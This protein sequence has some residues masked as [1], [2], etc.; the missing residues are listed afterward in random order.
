MNESKL[1]KLL[2][3][4]ITEDSFV[5]NRKIFVLNQ[6]IENFDSI[7]CSGRLVEGYERVYCEKLGSP[8]KEKI[9]KLREVYKK[10]LDDKIRMDLR[11]LKSKGLNE[12]YDRDSL[13]PKE[14]IVRMLMKG[15]KE[16]RAHIKTLPDIPCENDNG[17]RTICTKIPE[18]VHVYLTGRY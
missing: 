16:I 2:K 3:E 13:Y 9:L 6:I 8:S 15:P 12:S 1:K 5:L 14:S 4:T 10:K 18:V 7:D 17:E 11:R